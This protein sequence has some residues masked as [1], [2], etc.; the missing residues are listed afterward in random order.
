MQYKTK[1]QAIDRNGIYINVTDA[2]KRSLRNVEST[3]I[4]L[5]DLFPLKTRGQYTKL[6]LAL[7]NE[8]ARQHKLI[9]I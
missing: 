8:I 6:I 3:L 7:G 2:D 9:N 1:Q 4:A 5:G